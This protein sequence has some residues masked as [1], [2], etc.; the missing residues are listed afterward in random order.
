MK[1]QKYLTHTGELIRSEE[2]TQERLASFLID[3]CGGGWNETQTR[4][5]M[6]MQ[7]RLYAGQDAFP[8]SGSTFYYRLEM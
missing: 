5:A 2:M 1:L 3:L 6:D 7:S 8:P 4:R